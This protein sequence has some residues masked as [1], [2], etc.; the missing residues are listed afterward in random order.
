MDHTEPHQGE[1][2]GHGTDHP[3]GPGTKERESHHDGAPPH[4]GEHGG[5][6][7]QGE[8]GGQHH[9]PPAH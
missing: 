7:P 6:P 2:H 9:G 1:R 8:H 3:P 5:P 4:H